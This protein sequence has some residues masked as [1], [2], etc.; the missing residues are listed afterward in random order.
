MPVPP[1]RDGHDSNKGFSAACKNAF[2]GVTVAQSALTET[3]VNALL[4]KLA[5]LQ[6]EIKKVIVGQEEPLQQ[7]LIAFIAGGHC[8]LEGVPGLAKTLMIRTLAQA[9]HLTF[10]RIQFT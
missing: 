10:R 9:V 1:L 7:L 3:E 4:L 6:Q 2:M 8:L 5:G